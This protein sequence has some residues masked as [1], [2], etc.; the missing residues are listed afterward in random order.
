MKKRI[1]SLTAGKN[2][3]G[4]RLDR[5][6]RQAFPRLAL[7]GV[8]RLIRRGQIK[9]NGGKAVIGY[10]VREGDAIDIPVGID[11]TRPLSSALPASIPDALSQLII[12]RNDHV[13]A[14]NKPYGIL[15]HGQ[16]SL[17]ELIAAASSSLIDPSLSFRPGPVHRLDRNTTGIQLFGLSVTGARILGTL[18]RHH[19][20]KKIYCALLS[21]KID[22]ETE[23]HDWVTRDRA[24]KKTLAAADGTEAK[25]RQAVTLVLPLFYSSTASVALL[26][27]KTGRTHQLRMQSALHGHP[28]PGDRKYGGAFGFPRYVLHHVGLVIPPCDVDIPPLV[29]SFDEYTRQ[30]FSDLFGRKAV[31]H[32]CRR[33]D[34]LLRDTCCSF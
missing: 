6:I 17:T 30:T 25:A 13:M 4:K 3:E 9:V 22:E 15:A 1:K 29:A 14:V 19:Q 20:V 8:Y 26:L 34:N 2:D 21:G 33:V 27:P 7:A 10:R 18:F 31:N 32:I 5:V 28:L 23:W 12:F 11:R 16:G 24:R